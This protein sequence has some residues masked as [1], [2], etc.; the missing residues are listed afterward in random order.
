MSISENLEKILNTLPASVKLVAVSKFK[1]EQD[2]AEA[3]AKGQR[4]FGE[5]RA[6]ELRDKYNNLPKDIEWHFIGH[7]QTNKIKYIIPFVSLIHSVDSVGLLKEIDAYAKKAGRVVECLIQ[8]HISQEETKFGFSYE[9]CVELFNNY[10]SLE[11]ENVKIVGLMGMATNT[12]D[13]EQVRLEFKSLKSLYD[14]LNTEKKLG[15][16]VLSMGMSSDYE[17][18]IKEGSTMVRI[19]SSIFGSR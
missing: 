4:I 5:S 7:L 1:P 13:M 8:V 6:L 16:S 3:Y 19:G 2:I 10:D 17:L 12:D 14:R 11:L 15:F 18:A 9:E